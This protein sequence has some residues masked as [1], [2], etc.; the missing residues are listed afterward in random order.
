MRLLTDDEIAAEAAGGEPTGAVDGAEFEVIETMA[1]LGAIVDCCVVDLDRQGQG[2]LVTASGL[3]ASG[4]LRVVRNGIGISE[5]A[6]IDLPGASTLFVL[7][8]MIGLS[9]FLRYMHAHAHSRVVLNLSFYSL[10]LPGMKGVWSLRNSDTTSYHIY[11]VEAFVG[12]TRVL[13][14][15]DEQVSFAFVSSFCSG[16][17]FRRFVSRFVCFSQLAFVGETHVLAIDDEQVS[18]VCVFSRLFLF[19]TG[20]YDSLITHYFSS[21]HSIRIVGRD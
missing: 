16:F 1:N 4:S 15:D 2:L 5:E 14:I 17:F 19:L 3:D 18:C 20:F 12:E 21:A 8:L 11:L 6:A 9:C 13:A 10:L 7:F